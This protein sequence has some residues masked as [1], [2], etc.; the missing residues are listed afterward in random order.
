MTVWIPLEDGQLLPQA[1][2]WARAQGYNS[3]E[4]TCAEYINGVFA[5]RADHENL[6]LFFTEG[7]SPFPFAFTITVL[8]QPFTGLR[9]IAQGAR[10]LEYST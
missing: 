5:S 10:S 9:A 8:S 7:K 6:Q 3:Y 2:D 1:V 4:S